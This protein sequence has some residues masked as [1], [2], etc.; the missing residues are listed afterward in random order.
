MLE[1]HHLINWQAR[2]YVSQINVRGCPYHAVQRN[3]ERLAEF[4]SQWIA[5]Q[6][7]ADRRSNLRAAL[8][9]IDTTDSALSTPKRMA[10][11]FSFLGF[12]AYE[13]MSSVLTWILFLLG[14]AP[15]RAG[16]PG[17]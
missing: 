8:A 17:R 15:E 10:G 5:E 11:H 14:F 7:H 16:R 6:R 13:T 1:K 9:A 2:A 4:I 12:A 3:A